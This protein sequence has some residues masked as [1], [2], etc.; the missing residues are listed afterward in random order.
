MNNTIYIVTAIVGDC[1]FVN[2]GVYSKKKYASKI[3]K[4]LHSY[5]HVRFEVFVQKATINTISP[6]CEA[7]D[8]ISLKNGEREDLKSYVRDLKL[9]ALIYD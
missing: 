9:E 5:K 7:A 4:A 1:N 3:A 8:Y 6:F 2:I